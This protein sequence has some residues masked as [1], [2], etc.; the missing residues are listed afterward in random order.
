VAANSFFEKDRARFSYPHSC[1]F[2]NTTDL[3]VFDFLFMGNVSGNIDI[4]RKKKNMGKSE[5]QPVSTSDILSEEWGIL[6]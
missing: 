3:M 2:Y 5:K 4:D 1:S 6:N